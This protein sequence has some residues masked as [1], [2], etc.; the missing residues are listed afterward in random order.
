MFLHGDV[1]SSFTYH[2]MCQV[3]HHE[4]GASAASAFAAQR[5][6]IEGMR[7]QMNQ[8]QE[9]QRKVDQLHRRNL[10]DDGSMFGSHDIDPS[11]GDMEEDDEDM[12]FTTFRTALA[13]ELVSTQPGASGTQESGGK[14]R[15][16]DVPNLTTSESNNSGSDSRKGVGHGLLAGVPSSNGSDKKEADSASNPR[17]P[18]TKGKGDATKGTPAPAPKDKIKK[19]QETLTTK[20]AAFSDHT[21]W[22]GKLKSRALQA[23]TN[24]ME[25]QANKLIGEEGADQL[26]RELLDFPEVVTA[27]YELFQKVRKNTVSAIKDLL[28]HE[29]TTLAGLEPSLIAKI[30]VWVASDLLKNAEDCAGRTSKNTHTKKINVPCS[31]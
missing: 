19:A 20:K 12:S 23:L 8:A 15:K 22:E 29:L 31:Y 7:S 1:V 9:V 28:P 21:L 18:K 5:A 24:A 27:K 16:R 4:T 10:G 2:I 13:N 26:T 6:D 25:Q 3:E 11:A 14:R 30:I 17:L